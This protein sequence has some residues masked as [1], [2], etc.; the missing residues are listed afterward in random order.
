MNTAVATRLTPT[1]I[2][3]QV[4]SPHSPAGCVNEPGNRLGVD[5][6]KALVPALEQMPH[7]TK[8]DLYGKSRVT[9]THAG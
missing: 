3:T 5:G 8:L 6:A 4:F 1:V 9:V 7:M 2:M